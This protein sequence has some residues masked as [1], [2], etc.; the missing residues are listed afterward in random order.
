[1]KN[2]AMKTICAA[3]ALAMCFGLAACGGSPAP[4]G[5]TPAPSS[6]QTGT[7]SDA[8]SDGSAS[9]GEEYPEMTI[10]IAD[11]NVAN[12][13]PGIGTQMAADYIEEKSGGKIKC[14]TYI[15]GTL[16]E[17]TDTVSGLADGIADIS[18]YMI[19]LVAGIQPVGEILTQQFYREFPDMLG[20]TE[21]IREAFETIPEFQEEL[22]SQGVYC[23]TAVSSPES[24]MV[25]RD[26]TAN[27]INSV[28]GL[29]GK[30]IMNTSTYVIQAYQNAGVSAMSMGPADWY[31]N[32]ERGVCDALTLNLPCYNDFGITELI[33][34]YLTFGDNELG[35]S[36]GASSYLV[37][38][39]KWSSW[40]EN[41]QEL[42]MEG[43]TVAADYMVGRD[44]DVET[45]FKADHWT[46]DNTHNIPSA[47]MQSFY[48]VAL[49]SI[50]L[51]KEAV[52]SKGY[53]ADSIFNAYDA[54]V[55]SHTS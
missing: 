3:L 48:D 34:S 50:S 47:D 4:A 52:N 42:V 24:Y 19:G 36:A 7:P 35:G 44:Y 40:P 43:F 41:V 6:G 53:D 9:S 30:I 18:Y 2:L 1:M 28:E 25:F 23:L 21:I 55:A 16:M 38:Y 51:W 37:N 27:S 11:Y 46:D 49:D 54:I 8:P 14:E 12:S 32:F 17:S 29:K 39:E 31:S 26:N 22:I 20:N 10:V 5:T 33:G 45:Q 15:G 13:G